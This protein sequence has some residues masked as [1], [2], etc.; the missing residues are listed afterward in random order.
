MLLLACIDGIPF[1]HFVELNTVDSS[2]THHVY[3]ASG[4]D[5]TVQQYTGLKDKNGDEIYEGDIIRIFNHCYILANSQK[6]SEAIYLV[7]WW[8]LGF[9]FKLFNG[10]YMQGCGV[11]PD[12][13]NPTTYEIIGNIFENPDLL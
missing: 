13:N 11:I 9:N 3:N 6:E 4:L 7:E 8:G 12:N 2:T 5:L 1:A 10:E